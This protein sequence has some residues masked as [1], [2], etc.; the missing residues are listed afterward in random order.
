[1][2]IADKSK[3]VTSL[4]TSSDAAFVSD[5]YRFILLREADPGGLAHFLSR[6]ARGKKRLFVAAEIASSAEAQALPCFRKRV[7]GEVLAMHAAALTAGAWTPA[8][9]RTLV[10]RLDRYFSV[11]SKSVPVSSQ[12]TDSSIAQADDP[13]SEYLE[14]VIAKRDRYDA[15]VRSA[16]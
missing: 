12:G 14:S 13:F 9:R 8:R 15:F 6:L 2:A 3:F 5:C 16:A 11:L 1:M 4:E 10:A 7:V